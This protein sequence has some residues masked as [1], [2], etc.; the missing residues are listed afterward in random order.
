M[1]DDEIAVKVQSMP[2]F[3]KKEVLDYV[4]FLLNKH[5]KR[6]LKNE[7]F[8]FE[9]QDGLADIEEDITSVELAHRA[10]EWR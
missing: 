9:W 1:Q 3:L 7:E 6:K 2:E 5:E 10:L 8:T 4:E